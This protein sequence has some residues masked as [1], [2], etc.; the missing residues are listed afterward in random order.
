MDEYLILLLFLGILFVLFFYREEIF[1]KQQSQIIQPLSHRNKRR[2]GHKHN[3]RHAD[4]HKHKHR[5]R[6]K[7]VVESETE[8]SETSNFSGLSGIEKTQ[9][10]RSRGSFESR[11]SIQSNDTFPSIGSGLSHGNNRNDDDTF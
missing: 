6:H 11:Q 10:D 7:R 2:H 9:D 1:G 4:S 8:K 3:N 5:H